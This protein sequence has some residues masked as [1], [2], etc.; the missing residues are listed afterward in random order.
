MTFA[1]LLFV[2]ADV[3][4]SSP[5][6]GRPT[7]SRARRSSTPPSPRCSSARRRG[8]S[9]AGAS[10][11]RVALGLAFIGVQLAGWPRCGAPASRR[12]R[13]AT[14]RCSTRSA[15]FHALHVVVGL[16]GLVRRARRR[17][18]NWRCF[19]HFVGAVWLV[20]FAA[21]YLAGCSAA[22]DRRADQARRPRRRRATLK[23][24]RDAYQQYCRPCHGDARRRQAASRRPACARRRATSRRRSS[25][26]ATRRSAALPPDRELD[27]HR[28]PRP[29]RHGDAAVGRLRRASSTRRLAV[30][31]DLLAA[32][33]D[34]RAAGRGHRAVARSVRRRARP[35]R[36]SR[37]APSSS[38]ETSAVRHAATTRASATLQGRPSICLRVEAG[39]Q[40]RSTSASARFRSG[41]AA[42]SAR[43]PLRTIYRRHASSPISTASSRRASAAPACRP[44]RARSPRTS[45]GRSPTTCAR[46]AAIRPAAACRARAS[47]PPRRRRPTPPSAGARRSPPSATSTS[48]TARPLA[49]R[50]V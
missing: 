23:R 6:P 36:R 25:S 35:P 31:Q 28:A 45:S 8:R 11:R 2:W 47:S 37:A 50:S 7:V 13:A 34:R 46:C 20:L 32:L 24:G 29:Q 27:A 30:P 5:A 14:A 39:R 21:L 44:G 43:D 26:S 41:A 12:R 22:H 33:E 18:R 15:R 48:T 17:G 3:R 49:T 16:V 40:D 9:R 19:W 10:P 42:R 1:A 4:F 38:H